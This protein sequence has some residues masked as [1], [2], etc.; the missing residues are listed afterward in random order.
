MAI[1]SRLKITL[2]IKLLKGIKY[3]IKLD[4]NAHLHHSTLLF[5][6]ME[7]QGTV[8]QKLW[9]VRYLQ[10]TKRLITWQ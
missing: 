5:K 2:K 3:G 8:F 10:V 4:L 6:Q 9:D 7:S 1:F